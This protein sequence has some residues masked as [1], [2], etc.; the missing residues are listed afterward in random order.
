MDLIFDLSKLD[1]KA[2]ITVQLRKQYVEMVNVILNSPRNDNKGQ[3]ITLFHGT[4]LYNINQILLNGL[5]PSNESRI[6]N[7]DENIKSVDGLVYLTNKW[8][9]WYAKKACDTLKDKEQ[10]QNELNFPCYF[11]CTVDKCDFI[12]DEDFFHSLYMKNKIKKLLRHESRY[13]TVT[14]EECLTY[15]GTVAYLG[16]IPRK[17]IKNFTI[18]ASAKT[19]HDNFINQ[20]CQYAHDLKKWA[21]GKGKGQLLKKD[22]FYL[23]DHKYNLMFMMQDIPDDTFIERIIF[24][25]EEDKYSLVLKK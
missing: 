7:Y 22:L 17:N 19:F 6:S 15:Y 23:E 4:S 20:D 3:P 21:S 5:I 9:Y 8:H 25:K 11:D 12:L 10:S 1:L 24:N 16:K 2:E 13:M 14:A 18:L